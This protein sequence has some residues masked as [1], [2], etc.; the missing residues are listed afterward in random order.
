MRLLVLLVVCGLLVSGSPWPAHAAEP[1]FHELWRAD[2]GTGFEGWALHGAR[3][4]GGRLVLDPAAPAAGADLDGLT[5]PDGPA[6][7]AIGPIRE[8]SG[9]FQE[10]IPSWNAETPPGTWI[11]VRLRARLG[12]DGVRALDALV[13]AWLVVLGLRAGAAAERE[14]PARR[15]RPGLDRHRD[16][17][18]P[19]QRLPARR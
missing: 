2:R 17:G 4:D 11:E 18:G 8:T 13:R 1:P 6:G 5:V 9:P 15:G 14:G 10:L 7:L 19:G 16:P 3:V 12:A